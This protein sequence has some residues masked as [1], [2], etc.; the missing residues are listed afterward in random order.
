MEIDDK[1]ISSLIKRKNILKIFLKECHKHR[2]L[3]NK[4]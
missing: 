4:N 2:I 3:L 1:S